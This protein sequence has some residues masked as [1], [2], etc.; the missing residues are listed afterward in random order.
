MPDQKLRSV[1]PDMGSLE[2]TEELIRKRAYEFYEQRGCEHGHDLED[3]LKAEAEVMGK[4]V[5][6]SAPTPIEKTR[7]AVAA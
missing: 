3:W 7:S 6:D 2:L 1:Q 5:A 4:K